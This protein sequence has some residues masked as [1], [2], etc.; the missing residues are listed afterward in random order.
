MFGINLGG[1]KPDRI[2]RNKS[3]GQTFY[4]FDQ[5]DGMTDWYTK[6][7]TLDSSTK[8]PRDDDED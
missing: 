5:K 3:D 7:G 8:T 4:G 1:K 2:D 6:D